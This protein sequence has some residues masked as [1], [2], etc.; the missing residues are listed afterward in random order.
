VTR[1]FEDGGSPTGCLHCQ[2][3]F[4]LPVRWGHLYGVARGRPQTRCA[5]AEFGSVGTA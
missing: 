5:T 1:Y 4:D 2:P 3:Q